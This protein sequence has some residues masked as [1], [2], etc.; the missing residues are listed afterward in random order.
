MTHIDNVPPRFIVLEG[1]DGAGKTTQLHCLAKALADRGRQVYTT[2]EPTSLPSGVAI[3]EALAD[4]GEKKTVCQMA[5]MFALDRINHNVH[6]TEGI[7]S[8]LRVGYDVLCDRYYYSSLAYQGNLARN[9]A[10][11]R[12]LNYDCP[13]IRHPDLCIFLDL[14]PQESM[15]RI[16]RGRQTREIYETVEQLEAFRNTFLSVLRDL[17][18]RDRIVC[19][20][21]SDG[22]EQVAERIWEA[23]S[24]LYMPS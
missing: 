2:A 9:A 23:V 15:D 22:R 21:A 20:D 5:A 19:I 6:P 24:N 17:S 4:G 10:W 7:E 12:H 18:A 3:R 14:A 8:K 11:V 1:I 13:D 16:C